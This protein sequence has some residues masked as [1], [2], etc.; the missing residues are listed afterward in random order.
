MTCF[1]PC[2]RVGL[3]V[4]LSHQAKTVTVVVDN[5]S[6]TLTAVPPTGP[7]RHRLFWHRFFH[8]RNI[9]TLANAN[10]ARFIRLRVKAATPGHP[11]LAATVRVEVSAGYG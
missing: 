2:D 1:Y 6:L 7:H 5:R 9:A 3:A 11:T 4:W 10:G 8:D